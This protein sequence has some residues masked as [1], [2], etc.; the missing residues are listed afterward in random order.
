MDSDRRL[1]GAARLIAPTDRHQLVLM[2][3]P[4]RVGYPPAER[5]QIVSAGE[6]GLYLACA[7]GDLRG[8]IV[9]EHYAGHP[10]DLKA[11]D[12]AAGE[13]DAM[14]EVDW[15]VNSGHLIVDNYDLG[16]EIVPDVGLSPGLWRVRAAVWGRDPAAD[17]EEQWDERLLSDPYAVDPELVETPL[18]PEIWQVQLWPS[19][20]S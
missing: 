10:G 7:G 19:G 18:S 14:R 9:V 6:D 3:S 16:F 5:G 2:A 15:R 20:S 4:P 11:P 8:T 12:G 1:I 13:P 17:L